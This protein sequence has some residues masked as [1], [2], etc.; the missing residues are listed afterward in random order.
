MKKIYIL[1]AA[2]AVTLAGMISCTKMDHYYKDLIVER[3][4]VGVSDSMWIFTG[5]SRIQLNY[6]TP[7]DPAA[8]YLVV[9]WN[10]G[11]DSA[12]T[13]INHSVDTGKFVINN[14]PE[15][16]QTFNV[17]T[18]DKAGNR[19]IVKEISAEIFGESYKS[20]LSNRSLDYWI[21]Y[22]DSVIVLLRPSGDE[23]LLFSIIEYKDVNGET[24]A[25]RVPKN[26]S[27]ASLR[28]FQPQANT[29]VTIRS[30][31]YPGNK[32]LDTFYSPVETFLLSDF[33]APK[34][35]TFDI[36]SDATID[37]VDF[38][39]VKFYTYAPASVATI[40]ASLQ[41]T[42]DMGHLRGGGSK[43]N[44]VTLNSSRPSAFSAVLYGGISGFQTRNAGVFINLGASQAAADFYDEL[45]ETDRT[46]FVTAV[47]D[48]Q[49]GNPS[50]DAFWPINPDQVVLLKSMD[51]GIYVAMKAIRVNPDGP[52]TIEFKIS[53]P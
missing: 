19:S 50:A 2:I 28:N 38:N 44:F 42:F 11:R 39:L 51:R 13:E 40:P 8:Q 41:K 3:V 36:P 29:T 37:L 33:Q 26:G 14:V 20:R 16:P 49:A 22:S 10:N 24:K 17:I 15:G 45:D 48:A 5:D 21:P 7:T 52:M 25:V 18:T 35:M 32:V 9:K 31:F 30:G 1:Y 47:N 34:T 23:S 12:S 4:Y 6:L 53:R 27:A 46:S 43:H